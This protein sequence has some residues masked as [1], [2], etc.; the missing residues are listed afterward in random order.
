MNDLP[1]IY[2]R[3][4]RRDRH[5]GSRMRELFRYTVKHSPDFASVIRHYHAVAGV[6]VYRDVSFVKSIKPDDRAISSGWFVL[7][8][9]NEIIC[10]YPC[11]CV[12]RSDNC[13]K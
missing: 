11:V 2:R 10:Y 8:L 12:L 7:H 6:C 4:L 9:I 13:T 3:G 1:A 5:G